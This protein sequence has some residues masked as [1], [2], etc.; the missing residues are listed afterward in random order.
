LRSLVVKADE[1][2]L[3][4]VMK[5]LIGNAWKFTSRE[6]RARIQIGREV[7]RGKTAYFVRDNGVGFD[8]ARA[9]RLFIPFQ[10]LHSASE[11][12]GSGIGLATAQRIVRRHGGEIWA[13][14]EPGKGATFY[15]TLGD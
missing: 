2:L 11:F 9:D 12:E 15:F 13:D 7:V 6:K 14:S 3:R 1:G 5:N 8:M 10:R 4:A